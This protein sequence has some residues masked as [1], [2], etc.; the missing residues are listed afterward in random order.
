MYPSKKSRAVYNKPRKKRSEQFPDGQNHQLGRL[1]LLSLALAGALS[2]MV[3][4]HS[5]AD[6][7]VSTS[8]SGITNSGTQNVTVASSGTIV[9]VNASGIGNSGTINTLSNT[10]G[11]ASNYNAIDNASTGLVGTLSNSGTING[12]VYGVY[13]HGTINSLIND[14]G[15][16][17]SGDTYG[18]S[19]DGTIN[20]LIN[21]SGGTISSS[22]VGI[23]NSGTIYTFVNSGSI[24]ASGGV[25][26]SNSGT[27][28][29][30]SNAGNVVSSYQNGIVN[31]GGIGTLANSGTINGHSLAILNGNGGTIGLLSNSGT[32]G[33][34]A[35]RGA[36][37]SLN[38]SGTISTSYTGIGNSG[39]IGTLTNSGTISGNSVGLYNTGTIGTLTNSGTISGNSYAIYNDSGTLGTITNSGIIT[40]NI[41]S[42]SSNDLTFIGGTSSTFGTLTGYNGAISSIDN[43][44]SNVIFA[45][46]NVYLNDNINVG[47]YAVNNLA[48]TLQVN[49]HLTI[50]GNY[51]QGAGATL[52]IGVA[53]G[54]TSSGLTSD[55]GYGYLVVT[56]NSTI[57]AGSTIALKPLTSYSFAQGQRYVVVV[58][59]GTATYNASSLNYVVSGYNVTG[60]SVVDSSNNTNLVLTLGSAISN[61]SGSSSS[62]PISYATTH[63]AVSSLNGLFNYPG[64]NGSLLNVF[65]AAAALGSTTEAN[66][67]GAQLSPV[68]NAA[69]AAQSSTA[70]TGEV[71][72]VIGA[73]VDGL[74]LAQVSRSSGISAGESGYDVAVW[75]QVFGGKSNQAQRDNVSG[76]YSNYKG[77]LMGAD[78]LVA[79][80]WRVGGLASYAKT[81]LSNTGD[82]T[83]SSANAESY[84][85]MGYAGYTAERY[86]LDFSAGAVTHR[87]NTVREINFTG[88]SGTA[89][90][91][92]NGVQYVSSVRGGYPIKLDAW[93]PDT[94]LTPMAGLS[95]SHLRQNG[96]TETGGNGAALNVSATSSS[97][98]K[99]EVGAKLERSFDSS[100]GKLVPSIQ[101]GWRHEFHD[102]AQQMTA[103]Y[104]NDTSGST[105]FTTTGAST[106]RD[107]GV[108]ALALTLMRNDNLTLSARYTL[109]GASGFTGQ[110]ADVRLRY[111]F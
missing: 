2:A 6:T 108:V 63:N 4:S 110:T 94:T 37:S 56:G 75:G 23:S 31:N 91:Q 57:A 44:S 107:T 103:S 102:N 69:S 42:N 34:I 68:A 92:F 21:N 62:S 52:L 53:N 96:Y 73:H 80:D 88:F 48:S 7:I 93:M 81:S 10:G 83:G 46:G 30:L 43:T 15:A 16:T 40:G 101:L 5:R 49:N 13:N 27:I 58:T 87:Y 109:E 26:V 90:G 76:Y 17:L 32:I 95:Y 74:R 100:Y 86:Y 45:S 36:I 22:G 66:R 85:L 41:F 20:S 99:S 105:S 70:S 9:G 28:N 89:S 71:L 104:V 50:T 29:T 61:S 35:N 3:P 111:Q 19:N 65:N 39:T 12:G 54:A 59:A 11:I 8:Q 14:S 33:G 25:A 38:N 82:N 47:S 84:G 106:V 60:S 18:V 64:L 98:L 78:T 72:N 79:P 77:L 55:T 1:T 67:A 24:S 97:S 51:N